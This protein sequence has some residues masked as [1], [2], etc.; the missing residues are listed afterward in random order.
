MCIRDRFTGP[1]DRS[2]RKQPDFAS[3]QYVDDAIAAAI[4]PANNQTSFLVSGGEIVWQSAYTFLVSAAE[5]YILGVL[6]NSPQTTITLTAA[7]ATLD[8]IDII[9][10][11]ASGTVVKVDG[12]AAAQ[13][14]EPDIDPGTQL[15]LGIVFVAA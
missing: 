4:S 3:Q 10:V 9:A 14:S 12:T 5:Y 15:K 6:Y 13:P 2:G 8:R 7:H 11:T 1:G